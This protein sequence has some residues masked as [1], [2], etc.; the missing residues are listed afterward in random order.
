MGGNALKPFQVR[1]FSTE[2]GKILRKE[3]EPILSKYFQQHCATQS[4]YEKKDHGDMDLVCWGP[5]SSTWK[6]DL[7][8]ELQPKANKSN[9]NVHSFEY[10][11]IQVDLIIVGDLDNQK[12]YNWAWTYFSNNDLGNLIG[13]IARHLGFT[14]GSQ[15]FTYTV[16]DEEGNYKRELLISQDISEVLPFLGWSKS[17]PWGFQ[18]FN[19]LFEYVTLSAFFDP[20]IY[21]LENRNHEGR[22][23]DKQ[24]PNYLKFLQYIQEKYP[25]CEE[26]DFCPAQKKAHL[27]RAM[28]TWPELSQKIKAAHEEAELN[29]RIKRAFNGDHVKMLLGYEG[30]ELGD[31]MR[32]HRELTKQPEYY[33]LEEKERFMMIL[34]WGRE[35][36]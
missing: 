20:T 6:E 15:G 28:R 1:R 24:R 21:F 32:D 5:L 17:Y 2:E 3:L 13:R 9:S 36:K 11:G 19:E 18:T 7:Y 22:H 14:F 34:K 31:F 26:W 8:K 33:N 12:A 27:Y 30:K 23:R 25:G 10:K 16:Y 29:K 4:V 35:W